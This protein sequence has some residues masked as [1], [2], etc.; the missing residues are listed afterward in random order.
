MKESPSADITGV[1]I[2]ADDVGREIPGCYGGASH[3]TASI[4]RLAG[5]GMKFKQAYASPVCHPGCGRA[6]RYGRLYDM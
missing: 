5:R 2:F 3:S 6:L 4:D 1:M